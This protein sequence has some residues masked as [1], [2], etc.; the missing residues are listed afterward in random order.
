MTTPVVRTLDVTD[1]GMG[2]ADNIEAVRL[3]AVHR[4]RTILGEWF[5]D[6]LEGLPHQLIFSQRLG[7]AQVTAIINEELRKIRHVVS[8]MPTK[9]ALDSTTR[10]FSYA[11]TIET[12][13]SETTSIEVTT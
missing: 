12:D 2:T 10:H 9:V 11:A 13:F 6:I 5:L 7:V 3:Q 1:S 8:V 4:V